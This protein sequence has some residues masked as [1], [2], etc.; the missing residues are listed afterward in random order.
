MLNNDATYFDSFGVEHIPRE[1]RHSTGN[2]NMQSNIFRTQTYHSVISGY[3]C[4]GSI[5]HMFAGNTLIDCTSL[6]SPHY[7][8]KN[9]K[10]IQNH[11]KI[12]EI[13]GMYPSLSDQTQLR[14]KKSTKTKTIL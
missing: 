5:D 6:F 1:I 3:F 12:G 10:I 2:K 11:I 7:F 8:K 14:L 13:P 9:D 4:I